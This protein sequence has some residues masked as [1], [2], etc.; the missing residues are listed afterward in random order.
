MY[1]LLA[2]L[3]R[4]FSYFIWPTI[5]TW[6][7]PSTIQV[8]L[9]H[10]STISILSLGM[11]LLLD[12]LTVGALVYG[13]PVYLSAIHTLREYWEWR[14]DVFFDCLPPVDIESSESSESSDS[15]Q[16]EKDD[17]EDK[18]HDSLPLPELAD[19]DL[20]SDISP[21]ELLETKSDPESNTDTGNESKSESE[22]PT[23]PPPPSSTTGDK[24][25][26][27]VIIIV[28]C[29]IAGYFGK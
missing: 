1:N 13:A 14:L 6:I 18:D 15:S 4:H 7:V 9:I 2:N 24:I 20:N 23:P 29:F 16:E 11:N 19:V 28:A 8:L 5:N 3:S 17:V 25:L 21:S 22:T 12:T 10:G 26:A 27:I